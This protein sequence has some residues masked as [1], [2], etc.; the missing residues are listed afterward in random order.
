MCTSFIEVYHTSSTHAM[1]SCAHVWGKN[2]TVCAYY[3]YVYSF[4]R[5][6]SYQQHSCH[7]K[8]RALVWGKALT[9]KHRWWYLRRR[10]TGKMS[11]HKEPR[12]EEDVS[13]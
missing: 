4:Y 6:L 9:V 8:L 3:E 2:V 11:A 10:C 12:G 1:K 13:P 5:S 7:E